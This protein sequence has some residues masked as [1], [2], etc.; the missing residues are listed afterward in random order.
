MGD[1]M[2]AMWQWVEA[3]GD[4]AALQMG[5]CCVAVLGGNVGVSC[6]AVGEVMGVWRWVETLG[7]MGLF[8]VAVGGGNG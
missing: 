8:C 2:C 7:D 4:V 3:M 6:V 1:T 5:V